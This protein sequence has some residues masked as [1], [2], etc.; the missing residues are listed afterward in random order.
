MADAI[1]EEVKPHLKALGT[2]RSKMQR[3]VDAAK[4][5]IKCI[6]PASLVERVDF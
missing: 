5:S 6:Y 2:V 1:L 3:A 4:A